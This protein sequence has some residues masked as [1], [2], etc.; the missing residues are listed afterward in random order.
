LKSASGMP[1][2]GFTA[3][4]YSDTTDTR[5]VPS[6]KPPPR[7]ARVDTRRSAHRRVVRGR[8]RRPSKNRFTRRGPPPSHAKDR[9][10]ALPP[11]PRTPTSSSRATIAVTRAHAAARAVAPRRPGLPRWTQSHERRRCTWRSSPSR[12]SAM[13]VCIAPA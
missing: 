12:P 6:K 7:P 11:F 2:A 4:K 9:D 3:S 13:T 10:S 1:S 5:C 8:F